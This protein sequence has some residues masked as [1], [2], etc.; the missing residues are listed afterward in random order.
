MSLGK[1]PKISVGKGAETSEMKRVSVE[2]LKLQRFQ[3]LLTMFVRGQ[4]CFQ[5]LELKGV[6]KGRERCR[7]PN[8]G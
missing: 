1:E 8:H 4:C 7:Y 3:S 5:R 6:V 2:D